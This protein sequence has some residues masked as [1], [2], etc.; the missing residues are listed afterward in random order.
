MQ[1]Q[2]LPKLSFCD[3]YIQNER[4][5]GQKTL[6]TLFRRTWIKKGKKPMEVLCLISGST[7]D[8]KGTSVLKSFAIQTFFF[9]F[10]E[11]NFALEYSRASLTV[12][13]TVKNGNPPGAGKIW[14]NRFFTGTMDHHGAKCTQ[15]GAQT[16]Q[17]TSRTCQNFFTFTF[18]A[19]GVTFLKV[20]LHLLQKVLNRR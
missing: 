7:K 14:E 1:V 12:R 19:A 11:T 3:G 20:I 5:P 16:Y 18:K 2:K 6:S 15:I 8:Q 10:T 9:K 13:I 4:I 17:G